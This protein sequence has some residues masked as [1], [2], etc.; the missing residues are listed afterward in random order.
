M[1]K[2]NKI[3]LFITVYFVNES[4]IKVLC[5]YSRMSNIAI[6]ARIKD[7]YLPKS[8]FLAC[9]QPSLSMTQNV[10][11]RIELLLSAVVIYKVNA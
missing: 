10:T 3:Y 8:T 4:S 9:S 1:E 7:F 2:V 6:E 11:F 5:V